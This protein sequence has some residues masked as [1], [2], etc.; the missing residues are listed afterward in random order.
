MACTLSK[1]EILLTHASSGWG[2]G[3]PA[4]RLDISSSTAGAH[5][6]VS[7]LTAA[8]QRTVSSSSRLA[9]LYKTSTSSGR[10]QFELPLN[11]ELLLKGNPSL[12]SGP[13]YYSKPVPDA[14]T[15]PDDPEWELLDVTTVSFPLFSFPPRAVGDGVAVVGGAV[16]A[17][18]RAL[19]H[20]HGLLSSWVAVVG[21]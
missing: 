19:Q 15:K 20:D 10:R 6:T 12:Y 3:I 17:G 7:P 1:Q 16:E 11:F 5:R 2:R 9:R 18:F 4:D 21:R 8:A 13:Y 14:P